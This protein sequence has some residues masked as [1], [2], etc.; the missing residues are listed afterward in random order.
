MFFVYVVVRWFFPCVVSLSLTAHYYQYL[1]RVEGKHCVVVGRFFIGRHFVV[2]IVANNDVFA[3]SNDRIEHFYRKIWHSSPSPSPELSLLVVSSRRFDLNIFSEHSQKWK[4]FHSTS[5]K[6]IMR[7]SN[8]A[9]S[10]VENFTFNYF[11]CPSPFALVFHSIHPFSWVVTMKS[12][13]RE[14]KVDGNSRLVH[15]PWAHYLQ[16]GKTSRSFYMNFKFFR[17]RIW[18]C[19]WLLWVVGESGR[20]EW[21][22][23]M[24]RKSWAKKLIS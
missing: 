2:F 7:Y 20:R 21:K 11:F 5:V 6:T 22:H 9:N 16:A 17:K 1:C 10:R 18:M 24:E 19:W 13:E 14:R 8:S 23:E 3:T 12:K 4:L 15:H